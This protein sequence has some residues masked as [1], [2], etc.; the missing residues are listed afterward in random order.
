VPSS[1]DVTA[2]ATALMAITRTWKNHAQRASPCE[3]WSG[4]VAWH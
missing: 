2:Q 3:S 4:E 1:G